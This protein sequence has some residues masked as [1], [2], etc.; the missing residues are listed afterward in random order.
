MQEVCNKNY[1]LVIGQCSFAS[2]ISRKLQAPQATNAPSERLHRLQRR[3]SSL[4]FFNC[5]TVYKS[6]T[7]FAMMRTVLLQSLRF[8]AGRVSPR[9]QPILRSVKPCS[10]AAVTRSIPDSRPR[11]IRFYS[12]PSGLS[13][14]EVEGRIMD[15]LRNFDKVECLKPSRIYC[16]TYSRWLG[17][18]RHQGLSSENDARMLPNACCS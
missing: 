11:G 15:I 17:Y 7:T 14:E 8:A 18:G 6:F 5:S 13:K 10:Y 9:S 16:E 3:E 1:L 2:V 4:S 12:A